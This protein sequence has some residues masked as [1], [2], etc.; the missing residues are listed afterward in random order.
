MKHLKTVP[1]MGLLAVLLGACQT[2]SPVGSNVAITYGESKVTFTDPLGR[3]TLHSAQKTLASSG[4]ANAYQL[5]FTGDGPGFG[6]AEVV[7]VELAPNYYH[8]FEANAG[9]LL[10]HLSFGD[11]TPKAQGPVRH[12]ET[13]LGSVSIQRF[14][15]LKADC[16]AFEMDVD[17]ALAGRPGQGGLGKVRGTYCLGGG[18]TLSDGDVTDVVNAVGLRGHYEPAQAGSPAGT[19]SLALAGTWENVTDDL[20]GD[21]IAENPQGRNGRLWVRL[22]KRQACSG[23]WALE[24]MNTEGE[25]GASGTW[26]LTCSDG[27]SANG[28][29]RIIDQQ[30]QG[31]GSDGDGNRLQFRFRPK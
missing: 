29:Y 3:L 15:V 13:P 8:R 31:T 27:R 2:V 14:T 23:T 25:P 4:S 1:V 6:R 7:Y 17:K 26:S 19:S 24:T 18:R 22:P 11:E 28:T 10:D 9:R 16:I 12:T 30:G 20:K 21:F 5:L